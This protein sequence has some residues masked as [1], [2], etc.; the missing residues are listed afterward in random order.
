MEPLEPP[1]THCLSAA[2]GWMEL[3]NCEEAL[4]ELNSVSPENKEHPD[5]LEVGWLICAE[6]KSWP[7]ALDFARRLLKAAPQRSSGWLHQAYALRRIPEGTLQLAW[8][9]L[10][11]A[12]GRFPDEPTIP[13]NL[14]CYACQ[15]G[16]LDL[17]RDW[18][19]RAIK[20]SNKE[21]VQTMALA[22]EDL[23]PL[24]PELRRL[25]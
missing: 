6:R 4:F 2:I 24:W 16:Q 18:L 25:K 5:V 9:A 3:G 13:Y 22:D 17:A 14:A 15:M 23:K 1:D 20:A 21:R 19:N 8:D 7:E 12:A 10:L 11:P